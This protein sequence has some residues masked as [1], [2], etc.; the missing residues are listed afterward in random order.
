VLVAGVSGT[1]FGLH[2]LLRWPHGAVFSG[3]TWQ[4]PTIANTI[5][6]GSFTQIYQHSSFDSLPL[7]PILLVPVMAVADALGLRTT[8][9]PVPSA[10]WAVIPYSLAAGVVVAHSTRK[11]VWDLGLRQRV[12]IVQA[13]VSLAV[14][15]PCAVGGH[16]E[17]ALAFAFLAYSLQMFRRGQIDRAALFL[18]LAVASKQWAVLVVP[19]MTVACGHR[20][21]RLA[22]LSLVIPVSLGLASLGL[23]YHGAHQQLLAPSV[24]VHGRFIHHGLSAWFGT[25]GSALVRP[26]ELAATPIIA[27]RARRHGVP[28][29]SMVLVGVLLMRPLLEPVLYS[30]YLSPAIALLAILGAAGSGRSIVRWLA[31]AVGVTFWS[32]YPTADQWLW[33]SVELA[34]LLLL[35]SAIQ[36]DRR[37]VLLGSE[38]GIARAASLH[39]CSEHARS[40]LEGSFG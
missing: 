18:G 3:D 1:L 27:M 14:V 4:A 6:H 2:L 28:I 11:L 34:L 8:A 10:A 35:I 38:R 15:F 24:M 25:R 12:W 32:L 22:F 16:M 26:I 7:W 17:D 29:L 36:P 39:D 20:R 13:A 9:G 19:A 30:Y 33:W 31:P 37:G 21:S 23:D 5:L 40:V